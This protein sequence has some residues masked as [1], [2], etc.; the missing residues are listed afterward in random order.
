MPAQKLQEMKKK[1]EGNQSPPKKGTADN[2]PRE[3]AIRRK[4]A[5]ACP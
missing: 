3:K 5:P 4:R 2:P 1:D